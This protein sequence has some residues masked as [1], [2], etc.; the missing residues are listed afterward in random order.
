MEETGIGGR[1][2]ENSGVVA[3]SVGG[4]VDSI[5]FVGGAR[6]D[7]VNVLAS[8]VCAFVVCCWPQ[9]YVDGGWLCAV[10]VEQIMAIPSLQRV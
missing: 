5:T 6:Q 1:K 3:R 10:S 7:F 9:P 4:A 2:E 8:I